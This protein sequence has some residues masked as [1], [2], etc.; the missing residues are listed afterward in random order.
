MKKLLLKNALIFRD[1]GFEKTD[2]LIMDG[3]IAEVRTSLKCEDA[4]VIDMAG[5]SILPG[6][7]D[8]HVHLREPG[9][10]HKETIMSGT[11]A[12]ARAGYTD[13]FTMPNLRPAP[14]TT[15]NL[16]V[17]LRAIRSDAKINVHP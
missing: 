13:V 15:E 2:I 9:F 5:L 4:E 11:S 3:K 6:L 17:Q 12:A 14:D 1:C 8:L 10:E 16:N 7:V